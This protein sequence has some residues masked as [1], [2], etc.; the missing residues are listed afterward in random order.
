MKEAE[1]PPGET[2]MFPSLQ[3]V[4]R[5]R[6]EVLYPDRDISF[7]ELPQDED[8]IHWGWC[9]NDKLVSVISLF[10]KENELQFRKFATLKDEQGKGYGGRLLE[11]VIDYA[12]EK[13]LKRIWCNAR[14]EAIELYRRYGLEPEGETWQDN[15]ITYTKMAKKI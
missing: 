13:G 15:G 4:Y 7:V 11:K 14:E 10:E 5:I 12:T 8:A 6:H 2:V 9:V 1:T 3:E